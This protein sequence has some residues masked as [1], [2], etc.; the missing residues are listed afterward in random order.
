VALAYL[1]ILA[2]L[3]Q[4]LGYL[5]YVWIA[6]RGTSVP[7]PLSWLMF[8]YGTF[9]L[10]LLEYDRDGS[11]QVFVLPVVCFLGSCVVVFLCW[12]RGGFSKQVNAWDIVSLGLDL[13]VTACYAGAWA[14]LK[15]GFITEAQRE[16]ATVIMLVAWNIG[17]FTAFGPMLRDVN[18]HPEHE[19]PLPWFVWA[20]AYLT[21]LATTYADGGRTHHEL[22]LYPAVNLLVHGTLVW[23]SRH[24]LR[25]L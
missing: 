17:V 5:F 8:A 19:H 21:L 6:V 23:K 1:G 13:L 4:A 2:G 14:L 7:N 16:L 25:A 15:W 9:V 24:R 12:Q 3:L 18:G 10:L 11:W 20:C 22:L